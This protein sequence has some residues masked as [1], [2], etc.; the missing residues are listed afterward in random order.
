MQ[1]PFT[2]TLGMRIVGRAARLG[3]LIAADAVSA[4]M[5]SRTVTGSWWTAD[6]AGEATGHCES[7]CAHRL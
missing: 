5:P 4:Y 2:V 7:F 6:K 1:V 3:A